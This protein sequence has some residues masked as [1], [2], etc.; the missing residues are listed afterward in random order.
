LIKERYG[1]SYVGI[2]LPDENGTY[3]IARA[4]TGEAE[5]ALSQQRFRAKIG[6]SSI[7]GWVAQTRR[8]L[9]IDNISQDGRFLHAKAIPQTQSELALPLE[10]GGKL[11]GVLDIQSDCAAAF[12]EKDVLVFQSLADQVVIALQN[13]SLYQGERSRRRLAE[14]LYRVGRALTGTLDLT[15]VLDLILKHLAEIVPYDRAAVMLRSGDELKIVA[16]RGFPKES[17]PLQIRISIKKEESE[18]G[19]F[20]QIYR[21]QQPLV[22]ADALRRPDWQH[23]VLPPAR[24]W[25]GVPLIRHDE[26]IGM[27]SVTRETPNAYSDE[28]ATLAAT[29]A[30][31]AAIALENAR[32]YEKI[33]RFNQV[34]GDIVRERTEALQAAFN[35]LELLDRTKSNFITVASHELRTPLTVLRGYS[36]MLLDDPEIQESNGQRQMVAGICSGAMRLQEIVNS[37]LDMAKIDSRA[38]QLYPEPLSIP[39]LLEPLHEEFAQPLTER[40]LTLQLEDMRDLPPIEADPD[41]LWKIFYHLVSNAIKYTPDGGMITI[42]GRSLED[43]PDGMSRGSVEIIVSDTGIGIDPQ[44]H[45]L[46]FSKFYQTGRI[47]LHSTDQTKFKGGGTG[48]GLAIAQGI[49]RAHGGKLWVESPGCDEETCPGSQFHVVLPLRQRVRQEN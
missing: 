20:P 16:A 43:R 30:G 47:S 26:V 15:E 12:Q 33:T 13:A 34:L 11:L 38:L 4:D 10:M 44:F 36:Q 32:L 6:P 39:L 22:I 19:I 25:L 24:A 45:K 46:I 8:P 21:T 40:N 9:R 35:Q 18:Y 49:V 1:Y 23:K 7:I 28:D 5:Q 29:F 37:L 14:T 2:F 27:L 31:Q 42:S 3:L 41:A 17:H 48:L